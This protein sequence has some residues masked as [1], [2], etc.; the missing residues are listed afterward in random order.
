MSG[1]AGEVVPITLCPGCN[2]WVPAHLD[3][4]YR[5][6]D[7]LTVGV[8]SCPFEECQFVFNLEE[9]FKPEWVTPEECERRTGWKKAPE[10]EQ[11]RDNVPDRGC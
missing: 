2:R 1:E 8:W 7:D 5:E 10:E 11:N 9:D 4:Y 3:E 6:A